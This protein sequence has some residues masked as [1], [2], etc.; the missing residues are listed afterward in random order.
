MGTRPSATDNP[1]ITIV[2]DL[3]Y[4]CR[5]ELAREHSG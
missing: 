4:P 5:S 3:L 2:G 1:G